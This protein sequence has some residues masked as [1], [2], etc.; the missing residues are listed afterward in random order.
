M[1]FG[2]SEAPVKGFVEL[3]W[4]KVK[5]PNGEQ[6]CEERLCVEA[7]WESREVNPIAVA[8]DR[9]GVP[10]LA[11]STHGHTHFALWRRMMDSNAKRGDSG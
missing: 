3:I 2:P 9:A 8:A 4:A 7:V 11:E 6:A 1:C 10:R 5:S